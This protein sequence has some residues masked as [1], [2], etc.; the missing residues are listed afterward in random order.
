MLELN[1]QCFGCKYYNIVH[2]VRTALY[3]ENIICFHNDDTLVL[4]YTLSH[5]L[6]P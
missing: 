2:F 1:F 3:N 6:G 4:N 5:N